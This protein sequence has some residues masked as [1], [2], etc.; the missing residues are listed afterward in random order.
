MPAIHG[1]RR[2]SRPN[3]GYVGTTTAT[4]TE[5]DAV[6]RLLQRVGLGPRPGELDSSAASSSFDATLAA[7]TTPATGVDAG[8]AATP[9]PVFGPAP[10]RLGKTAPIAARHAQFREQAEQARQL[11]V[12]WLDRMSAVSAPFPE[13]MTWFWHGHFATS[14]KKVHLAQLMSLQND[15]QRRLGRGDFR[16]LAQAMIIDPAMLIW[17]DGGGNRVGRPNENLAREFM[18]LFTLGVGNYSETDVRQAARAL[19]GWQVDYT[20]DSPVFH[21][22]AHD[23]GPETVLGAP[24]SYTAPSLV[25]LVITQPASP[26][27]L[28]QRIWTRFVADTPPDPDTLERLVAAYG[29]GHDITA[30]LRAAVSSPT[31]RAPTSVLVREPVLW[32]VGALRALRAPASTLAPAALSAALNGLG[33]TPFAPPNV[34]G[35]PAGTPW[36]TTAAAMTRLRVARALATVGD[37]SPV[38]DAA[39]ATRVDATAALLG[40]PTLTDRTRTALGTLTAQPAQLVALALASPENTVV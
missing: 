35:W 3:F 19:T 11:V 14:V 33:Q 23:A 30:L 40:L 21:P 5:R 4:I 8:V 12:W 27:F 6:R 29:P 2:R 37:I 32:L 10:K 20:T 7:L 18:E 13:R 36:L 39:P 17:L 34:G 22:R 28:A 15:T 38:T 26:R 24:G 16:A 1:G 9:A 31:F 25:D